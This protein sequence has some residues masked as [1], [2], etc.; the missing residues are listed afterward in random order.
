[1]DSGLGFGHR[2]IIIHDCATT[3]TD[4]Y[5]KSHLNVYDV[6]NEKVGVDNEKDLELDNKIFFSYFSL[7]ST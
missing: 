5:I 6:Y 4:G 2:Y 3:V 7:I 1:M